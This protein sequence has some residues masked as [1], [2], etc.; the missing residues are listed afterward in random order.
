MVHYGKTLALAMALV[1]AFSAV[2]C[3]TQ[4][5]ET[6]AEAQ[7]QL[8]V[9]DNAKDPQEGYVMENPSA[10]GDLEHPKKEDLYTVGV[11]AKVKQILKAQGEVVRVVVEGVYR[12]RMCE[13]ITDDRSVLC[14]HSY[15]QL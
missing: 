13:L 2:G 1:L 11:V 9:V 8:W 6:S 14:S 15:S 10:S 4:K 5:D 12:A 3:T 7:P